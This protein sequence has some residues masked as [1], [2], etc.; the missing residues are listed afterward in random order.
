MLIKEIA[1]NY[2]CSILLIKTEN[3]HRRI[4]YSTHSFVRLLTDFNTYNFKPH[5]FG[6]TGSKKRRCVG[7]AYGSV[8]ERMHNCTFLYCEG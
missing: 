4:L 1:L 6:D 5:V 3:L 8:L 2:N 7:K